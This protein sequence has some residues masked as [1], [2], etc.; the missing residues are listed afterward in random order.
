M[1]W[2]GEMEDEVNLLLLA[3]LHQPSSNFNGYIGMNNKFARKMR[4]LRFF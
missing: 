3:L 1:D 4:R 2:L